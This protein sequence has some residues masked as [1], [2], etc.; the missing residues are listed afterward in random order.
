MNFNTGKK[1]YNGK[2]INLGDVLKNPVSA[3]FVVI[4]DYDGS[5]IVQKESDKE[6]VIEL[7]EFLKKFIDLDVVDSILSRNYSK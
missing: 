5:I 3:R 1:T 4:T 6:V 7:D 2:D